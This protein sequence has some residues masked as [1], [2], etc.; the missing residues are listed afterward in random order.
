MKELTYWSDIVKHASVKSLTSMIRL[1]DIIFSMFGMVMLFP[2][3]IVVS[4]LVK[5]DHGPAFYSQKRVGKDGKSF[6]IIKF[7]SMVVNAEKLGAKITTGKDPRITTVGHFLRKTKIDELP[8]L[9]N[10]FW[11]NMSIVGPRPEVPK[12]VAKWPIK[13]KKKIL[14]VK[15]GI[16]D[17]AS[18][19]YSNEQE[20][21]SNSE[22]PEKLYLK[23]IMPRKLELYLKYVEERSLWLNFR[24][25]IT[26]IFKIF[27]LNLSL[28]LPE[29]KY[30]IF[31][32]NS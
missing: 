19:L 11:G 13:D 7:R 30:L 20:L 28:F 29:I 8:Q 25:I 21:L 17:Y 16:T 15:P 6:R 23:E 10:V 18:L 32:N 1:V 4:V 3:L 31:K 22:K 27:G 12:Y 2:L 26:T 14:S 5:K 9:I 24:I